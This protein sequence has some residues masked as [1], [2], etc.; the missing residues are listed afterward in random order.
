MKEF[1]YFPRGCG[2]VREWAELSERQKLRSGMLKELK[3]V[4]KWM[5]RSHLIK[6]KL[7]NCVFLELFCCS[8]RISL[9]FFSSFLA[10]C[11]RWLHLI[12]TFIIAHRNESMERDCHVFN[13]S[14]KPKLGECSEERMEMCS[15]FT[16]S[17]TS[18]IRVD[19]AKQ[20]ILFLRTLVR[21]RSLQTSPPW[22]SS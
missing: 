12:S 10:N 14:L 8:P 21:L 5:F 9:L 22:S 19:F 17:F 20:Q 15:I 3:R 13:E 16:S 18:Y 4:G 1:E 11:W 6:L 2:R 7:L